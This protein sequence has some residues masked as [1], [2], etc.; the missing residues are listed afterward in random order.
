MKEKQQIMFLICL[1]FLFFSCRVS[2]ANNKEVECL[3][4]Y[5]DD[6]MINDATNRYNIVFYI[7]SCGKEAIPLLI[8]EIDTNKKAAILVRHTYDSF[9]LKEAYTNYVGVLYAYVIEL[10][11]GRDRLLPTIHTPIIW[12]LGDNMDI[13]IYWH[14]I[15][16]YKDRRK[17][18]DL[19]D[20]KV[21]KQIY[22]EWWD[23]NKDRSIEKLRMDWENGI[24]PLTGSDYKWG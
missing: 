4:K 24:K 9:I 15:I 6:L 10:I 12:I 3:K 19:Y 11:L 16:N 2:I 7:H 22:Q 21:I 13:Y 8:G 14:G 18:F 17:S 23:K 20:M 5:I 1:I